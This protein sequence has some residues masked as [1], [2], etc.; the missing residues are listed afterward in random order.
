MSEHN[1]YSRWE[2]YFMRRGS[3]CTKFWQEYLSGRNRRVLFI[4]GLGFDPRMCIGLQMFLE[5]DKTCVK[6]C[7]LIK[8]N[9]GLN[10][11]S[12]AYKSLTDA[13]VSCIKSL[14]PGENTIRVVD[15]PMMSDDSRRIGSRRASD[16]IASD[17]ITKYD[18]IVVDI[19]A[20]PRGIYFPIITK[21]L[22][23]LDDRG[24]KQGQAI[25][26]NLHVLVA[27][28]VSID[29]NIR[30]QG[31]DDNAAYM[32]GF[33]SD[34]VREATANAPRIW[35][36]VLGEGKNEQMMRLYDHVRPDEICPVFPS[37]SANPRRADDLIQEYRELLFDRLRVEPPNI[38]YASEWNPFE[39]YRQ[40]CRTIERY[41]NA[42]DALGKCKVV[43]SALS[44]KLLSVGALLAAYEAKRNGF[45]IGISHV[46]THGYQIHGDIK[47]SAPELYSLWI[48]GECY[49]A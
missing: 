19:S 28:E 45:M 4:L 5:A 42:L 8:Y 22:N 11:P 29:N 15:V 32:Y 36:P 43:V 40:I 27:E 3:S 26:V 41:N 44:S 2:H 13:N 18:D 23:L 6:D 35:I 1:A 7:I 24:E 46:E 34:L 17:V 12:N 30:D 21:L 37:P 33:S 31:I 14:L 25:S 20:M 9:E 39:V 10:S 49:D 38:I 16:A 48:A 47:S